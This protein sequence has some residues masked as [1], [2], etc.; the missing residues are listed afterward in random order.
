MSPDEEVERELASIQQTIDASQEIID[1]HQAEIDQ[2]RDKI[3]E[4][5][6]RAIAIR[7]GWK[8][9]RLTGHP[10]NPRGYARAHP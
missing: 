9:D 2:Q 1:R 6:A 10:D 8:R 3:N 7:E 4:L 5:K